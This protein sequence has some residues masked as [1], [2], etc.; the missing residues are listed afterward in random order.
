MTDYSSPIFE[1]S[2]LTS[3]AVLVSQGVPLHDI[4]SSNS[5]RVKFTFTK[6]P[7]V[8]ELLESLYKRTLKID[9][10]SLVEGQKYVKNIIF[11]Y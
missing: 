6:T 3:V 7:K 9:P 1:T 10:I 2:D 4:D 5:E 11:N 8:Q